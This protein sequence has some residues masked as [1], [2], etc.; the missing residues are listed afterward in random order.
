[1]DMFCAIGVR[2]LLHVRSSSVKPKVS[3]LVLLRD[4]CTAELQYRGI[5]T[6]EGQHKV[7]AQAP[8]GPSLGTGER[9]QGLSTCDK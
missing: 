9:Q 3:E 2:F 6:R 7:T 4:A 5:V 8:H 1:V